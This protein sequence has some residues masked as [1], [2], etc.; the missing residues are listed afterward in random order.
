MELQETNG[1]MSGNN[2][3]FDITAESIKKYFDHHHVNSRKAETN[4]AATKNSC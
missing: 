4:I 1:K 2:E 3:V